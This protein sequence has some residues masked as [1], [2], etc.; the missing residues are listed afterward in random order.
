MC[1]H[2]EELTMN[3]DVTDTVQGVDVPFENPA[4]G[5][6]DALGFEGMKEMM[7]RFYDCIYES[8]IANFFPQ[9]EEEFNKVKEKNT[10]FFIEICGG[11]KVYKESGGMELNEFMIRVH[12]DF[13]IYEK[14]R[15]EWL[16]CMKHTLENTNVA[17]EYKES[18][19]RYVEAFSKLTVNSFPQKRKF[20]SMH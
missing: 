11:P 3:Y 18:F 4:K 10:L 6:Y 2:D 19:W 16:G 17:D 20:E 7:Y 5:F 15:K 14:S 9:D 12:D 13:S 8:D 1:D